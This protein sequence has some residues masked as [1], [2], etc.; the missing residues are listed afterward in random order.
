MQKALQVVKNGLGQTCAINT[1]P[2]LGE[3]CL[4][5]HEDIISE[6]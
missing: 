5:F 4:T 6:G 1:S 2:Y 3:G